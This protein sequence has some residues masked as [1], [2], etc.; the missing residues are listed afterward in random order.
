MARETY[1]PA[2]VI[3]VV[4][5]VWLV[6]SAFLWTHS[7]EQMNNGWIVGVL[8]TACA[9]VAMRVP[10]V[11]YLNTVLAVWLFISVW[12]L[13]T[14]NTA[15]VWNNVIVAIAMFFAS[16]APGYVGGRPRSIPP[17]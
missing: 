11:R 5:G 6:V 14:I 17:G 8:A 15:T 7:A 1:A 10:E 12:A 3:N 9:L 4:L 2:R 13:P 16:L